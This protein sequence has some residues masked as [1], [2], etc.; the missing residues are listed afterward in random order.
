[1]I[2]FLPSKSLMTQENQVSHKVHDGPFSTI[3]ITGSHNQSDYIVRATLGPWKRG[4][5]GLCFAY[6]D[7]LNFYEIRW[8]KD[9][10]STLALWR[11]RD[12]K[13]T[14]LGSQKAISWP[15]P[16][17][18]NVKPQPGGAACPADERR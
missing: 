9:K 1:M 13:Q 16:T 14:R 8:V 12:G 3:I 17:I 5:L 2:D 7:N 18:Q 11:V 4:A 15:P 10:S 6:Q